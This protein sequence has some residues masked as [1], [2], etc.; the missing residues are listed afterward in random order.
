MK[1]AIRLCDYTASARPCREV[2]TGPPGLP[3]IVGAIGHKVDL[4]PKHATDLATVLAPFVGGAQPL[5]STT[6][7]VREARR[8]GERR[9]R[10]ADVRAWAL[11]QGKQVSMSGRLPDGLIQNYIDDLHD[12]GTETHK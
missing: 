3:L 2:V 4:C 6:A 5:R 11:A 1:E 9:P 7:H 8:N 12:N 10:T